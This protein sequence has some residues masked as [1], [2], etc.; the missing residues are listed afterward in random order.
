MVTDLSLSDERWTR[1]V[2]SRED[3]TPFHHPAWARFLADCYGFRSF[4]LASVED[5]VIVGGL[6][7]LETAFPWRGRKWHSLPFTDACPPLLPDHAA[8]RWCH[9][10]DERRRSA[11]VST[12]EV[13]GSMP[14]AA[15]RAVAVTHA[16]PLTSDL[17][18][19]RRRWR[20][21]AR[22]K[23]RRAN[24]MGVRVRSATERSELDRVFYG[25]HLKTRR[26][27][28]V[29]AQPRRFFTMLWDGVIAA[30][31]GE[32]LL[33][34]VDDRTVAGA[35]ILR[36]N[37]WAT[38]KFGASHDAYWSYRPNEAVLWEGMARSCASGCHRFDFGRTAFE[39]TGL[40][41]FKRHLGGEESPLVYSTIGAARD[42]RDRP[43][44]WM[45]AGS[46]SAEAILRRSPAWLTG[47]VGSLLYRYTA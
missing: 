40:R 21:Q 5:D 37:G 12:L 41:Q 19:V 43:A 11:G 22:R 1:F 47:A 32:V 15:Q 26:R 2:E 45:S 9:D 35:V 20:P 14:G 46:R 34:E 17:E 39:A 29:P 7:V 23:L 38:Y 44:R 27:L 25:L 33:A 8:V 31:L 42:D 24:E 13:R 3:A 4:V 18:A 10:V 28:G 16:L 36:W 6:P 30:G